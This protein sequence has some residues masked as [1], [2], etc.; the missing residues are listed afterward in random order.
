MFRL[1]KREFPHQPY[2]G[3][4]PPNTVPVIVLRGESVAD[5]ILISFDDNYER[6]YNR[7]VEQR[8]F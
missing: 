1:L 8:R 6:F 3:V 5:W 2:S 4:D 7:L